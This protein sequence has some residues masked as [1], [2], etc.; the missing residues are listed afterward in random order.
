MAEFNPLHFL[1]LLLLILGVLQLREVEERWGFYFLFMVRGSIGM[2]FFF[3]KIE[4]VRA[5]FNMGHSRY[6]VA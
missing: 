6:K 5:P 1:I 4:R 3:N 2:L